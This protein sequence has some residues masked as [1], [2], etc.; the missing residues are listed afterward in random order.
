MAFRERSGGITAA[1][2]V[3]FIGSGF[4]ALAGLLTCLSIFALRFHPRPEAYAPRAPDVIGSLFI[5][6]GF[7]FALAAWGITSG[8]GLLKLKAW[9]RMSVLV[10]SGFCAFAV[11]SVAIVL[12]VIG[13]IIPQTPGAPPFSAVRNI[14]LGVITAPL[15]IAIWWLVYFNL[16]SVR[17]QFEEYPTTGHYSRTDGSAQTLFLKPHPPLS[18]VL[19][20]CV[21]LFAVPGLLMMPFRNY[22]VL[23]LGVLVHG[24][25]AKTIYVLCLPIALYVG[26]GLLKLKPPARILA[27]ALCVFHLVNSIAFAL[28]PGLE[29]RISELL[30]S[31]GVVL[32]AELTTGVLVPLIRFGLIAGLGL[33]AAIFWILVTRKSAFEAAAAHPLGG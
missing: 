9:A 14:M 15:L 28:L 4:T 31:S 20:A 26:I 25:A 13:P 12:F 22:P 30:G 8:V 7:Y 24:M 5:A 1:A 33:S 6:V 11:I 23:L 21:Y 19:I 17:E 32:P 18:I 2:V 16:K 10:F 3:V 29:E 27:M